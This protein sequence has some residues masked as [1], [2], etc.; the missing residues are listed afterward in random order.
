[1]LHIPM[2]MN[3]CRQE[4]SFNKLINKRIQSDNK[5]ITIL[6]IDRGEKHLLYYSLIRQDGTIIKT[7]SWN[8][9]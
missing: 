5:D 6:G 7:G 8:T 4:N 1:M 2:T 9:V 3:F